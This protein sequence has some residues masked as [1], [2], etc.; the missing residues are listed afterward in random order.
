MIAK[1]NQPCS[2]ETGSA[3]LVTQLVNVFGVDTTAL[4]RDC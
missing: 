4:S 3:G 1:H 2:C